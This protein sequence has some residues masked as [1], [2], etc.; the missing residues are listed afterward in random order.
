MYI[1]LFFKSMC[2]QFNEQL[3]RTDHSRPHLGMGP[4]DNLRSS[5]SSGEETETSVM[6]H[7]CGNPDLSLNG[8]RCCFSVILPEH[9]SFIRIS[10]SCEIE[11]L[12]RAE[13]FSGFFISR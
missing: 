12:K 7:P 4:T 13:A 11:T 1:Q 3:L 5:Q 9:L 10:S 8:C 2:I 6:I